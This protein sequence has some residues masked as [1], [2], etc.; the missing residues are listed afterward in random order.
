MSAIMKL[1]TLEG[2]LEGLNGFTEPKVQLE[3]YETPAHLAATALYTIQT[4]FESIENSIVLDAGCG[5]GIWGIGAALLGASFVTA[6]DVDEHALNV[7]RENVDDMEITNIDAIQCDFLESSVCQW[8][9]YYD[10]VLMNPPFGTKNNSGID[11]QFLRMGTFL[12]CDSVYSLH[13]SSTRKHIE[14]KVKD[15]GM[16]G[17]VIAQMKYNLSQTY[18]FHKQHSM[19]IAVDIWRVYHPH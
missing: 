10:T 9:G 12:S 17:S 18:R 19:D 5:P 2:H 4:Q 11:M 3:Q 14:K 6:V 13:K 7:F 8:E 15:W 1:K 16:K